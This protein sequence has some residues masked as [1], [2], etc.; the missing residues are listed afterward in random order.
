MRKL[1]NVLFKELSTNFIIMLSNDKLY[2]AMYI[3]AIAMQ[4]VQTQSGLILV[5]SARTKPLQHS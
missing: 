1:S 2:T 5:Y 4:T 3:G